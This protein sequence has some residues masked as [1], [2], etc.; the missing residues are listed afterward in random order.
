[1]RT[2]TSALALGITVFILAG[3]GDEDSTQAPKLG[4]IYQEKLDK[5]WETAG[6]GEVPTFACANVVGTAV[7]MQSAGQG[8]KS[9]AVQAYEACYVDAFVHFS[10]AYMKTEGRAELNDRGQPEGC[11]GLY[12]SYVIHTNS[13]GNFAKDFDIDVQVLNKKIHTG[14]DETASLCLPLISGQ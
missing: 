13:L 2:K 11:I 5:A 6:K 14:L 9:E 1:M 7:G 3:C 10:N 8:K 4:G 12:T